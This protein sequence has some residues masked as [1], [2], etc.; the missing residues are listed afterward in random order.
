MAL[1]NKPL[2]LKNIL[3]SI[4]ER[5]KNLK[6]KFQTP[7]IMNMFTL[8]LLAVFE[9][10]SPSWITIL[11]HL[12]IINNI[13]TQYA[14]AFLFLCLAKQIHIKFN[15]LPFEINDVSWII[16]NKCPRIINDLTQERSKIMQTL[17]EVMGFFMILPAT[18]CIIFYSNIPTKACHFFWLTRVA[19]WLEPQTN[20]NMSNNQPELNL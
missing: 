7:L 5:I 12:L 9:I 16:K 10:L 13:I 14:V 4:P 1:E 18:R 15:F 2:L 19:K 8:H 3:T 20:Y 17:I 6:K 11:H